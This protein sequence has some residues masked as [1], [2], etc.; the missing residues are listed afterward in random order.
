ME[1]LC[2]MTLI[3]RSEDGF[4]SVARRGV[5]VN[6]KPEI[7]GESACQNYFVFGATPACVHGSCPFCHILAIPPPGI[8]VPRGEFLKEKHK[9]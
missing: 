1:K 6:E 4:H 8:L 3:T 2:R 7:L 9:I 5:T